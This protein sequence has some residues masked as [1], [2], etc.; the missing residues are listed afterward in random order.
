M[1]LLVASRSARLLGTRLHSRVA[2][3]AGNPNYTAGGAIFQVTGQRSVNR[4]AA[5]RAA[6]TNAR[7]QL[8]H[9]RTAH[10]RAAAFDP[11]RIG[12]AQHHADGW[13]YLHMQDRVELIGNVFGVL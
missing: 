4:R 9:E 3:L 6:P 7:S 11:L 2:R 12:L 13:Q 8:G 5:L 10:P 1:L